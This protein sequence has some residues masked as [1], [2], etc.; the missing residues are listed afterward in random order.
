MKTT[1]KLSTLLCGALLA[2]CQQPEWRDPAKSKHAQDSDQ[3]PIVEA[4]VPTIQGASP[5]I[6]QW[7]KGLLGKSP[8]EVF[9]KTGLCT[10]NTDLVEHKYAGPPA[11]SAVIGWGWDVAN[12]TRIQKVILVDASYK[13]VGAGV[14]GLPRPDVPQGS[15]EVPDPQ[16]GWRAHTSSTTGPLDAYG[17]L[18]DGVSICPLGHAEL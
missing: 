12:K 2:A 18:A 9:P 10:G 4:V 1:Q 13:I 16:T 3:A 17:I 15:P 14:G 6:A 11:G 5:G 8:R 7:A